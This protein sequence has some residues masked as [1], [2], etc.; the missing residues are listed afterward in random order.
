M[1]PL[2]WVR[3]T[4]EL[5]RIVAD[6]GRAPVAL[7]VEAD[8]YHHYRERVCLLQLSFSGRDVLVDTLGDLA[9]DPFR[10]LFEDASL[11]KIVHGAD[12][13]LRVLQRDFGLKVR[14]LFDTMIAARL[15]GERSFGL[16]ALLESRFGIRLDKTQQRADWSLRPLPEKMQVY[17]ADDVRH[18]LPLASLLEE[19]LAELGRLAWA[20]EEFRRLELVRWTGD[21]KDPEAYR[22]V[23]GAHDLD[24]RELAVLRELHAFRDAQARARD[25]PAFRVVRDEALVALSRARPA[26][27]ADLEGI[28]HL[29]QRLKREEG[30]TRLL[31][32]VARGSDLPE[33]LLPDLA[34]G[35]R[36]RRDRAFEG[37]VR[38]IQ[39]KR[40]AL[41][42]EV[43]IE[44]SVLASR[45]LLESLVRRLD[46]GEPL[47]GAPG[48]RDWQAR[49]LGPILASSF[50][51]DARKIRWEPP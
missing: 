40:D 22:K 11:R 39:K 18:L 36:Q 23:K 33:M 16:A 51:P 15:A 46:A 45:S 49:L 13:D 35:V 9:L 42:A 25:V 34:K 32:A 43:G 31:E 2:L 47:E 10:P 24:R 8:S 21:A 26:R 1:R 44:P 48:L 19:R 50:E 29:P 30:A 37:R 12:Y 28:P 5:G 27:A 7:D 38:E 17:A 4:D 41:A 3:T 6:V 14:G 20:E